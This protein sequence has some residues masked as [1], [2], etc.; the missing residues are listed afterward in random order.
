MKCNCGSE[1][2]YVRG[3][4]EDADYIECTKCGARVYV[5]EKQW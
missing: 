2:Q 5:N 1:M 3:M 4:V